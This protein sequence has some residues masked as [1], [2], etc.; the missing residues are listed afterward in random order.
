MDIS[1]NYADSDLLGNG[2]CYLFVSLEQLYEEVKESAMF[3]LP[4]L[5]P[6]ATECDLRAQFILWRKVCSPLGKK[7]V[8]VAEAIQL[9]S[10]F[11]L[12]EGLLKVST[13]FTT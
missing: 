12:I 9:A 11:H 13:V 2:G 4:L 5:D 7:Q 6:S 3:Y 8:S 1:R 10:G